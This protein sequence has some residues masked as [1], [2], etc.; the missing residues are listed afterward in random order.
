MQRF[1]VKTEQIKGKKVEITGKD[2]NHISK[3]LRMKK[4]EEIQICNEE[5]KK[6]YIAKIEKIETEKIICC[7]KEEIKQ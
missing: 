2:V 3:V 1:F 4:E 6:A 7:I 5:T